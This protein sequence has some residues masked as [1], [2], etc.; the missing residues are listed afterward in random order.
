MQR[1]G[2]QPCGSHA[3]SELAVRA[4]SYQHHDDGELGKAHRVWWGVWK[5]S[6]PFP[7]VPVP[8]KGSGDK[9]H[10]PVNE[11]GGGGGA[12]G[13]WRTELAGVPC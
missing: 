2:G 6:G 4:D 5:M 9:L 8:N 7:N 12:L 13:G 11:G 3:P 10:V 1:A